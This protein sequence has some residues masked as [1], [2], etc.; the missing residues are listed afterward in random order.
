MPETNWNTFH[1]YVL[2]YTPN[3]VRDEWVNIGVVLH[4]P[5]TA[6]LEA[7]LAE[8][9]A[10][11]ARVKRLHPYADFNILRALPGELQA[12]IESANGG[13][14]KVLEWMETTLSNVLQLSSQ[15]ALLGED[16]DAELDRLYRD[17]VSPPRHRAPA[18]AELETTRPALRVRINQAFRRYGILTKM[19]KSVRVEEFTTKGDPMRLDYSYQRNGTRGFLQAL[20]LGRDPAQAKVLAYTAERIRARIAGS[21]FTAISE[22]EPKSDNDRHQFVAG[23]LQEQGIPIVPLGRLDEFARRLAPALR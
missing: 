19:Q 7:R 11:L 1:F 12:R 4:D 3:L 17:Y 23:L 14:G 5:A 20:P 2:R 22:V 10:E 9:P 18:G 13:V 15:K 6:R 8:D 21:E 16:F